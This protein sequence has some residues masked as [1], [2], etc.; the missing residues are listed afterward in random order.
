MALLGAILDVGRPKVSARAPEYHTAAPP[1]HGQKYDV[2]ELPTM[3]HFCLYSNFMPRSLRSEV[4]ET[5]SVCCV[6][7]LMSYERG[8]G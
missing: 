1:T 8:A 2:L 7:S 5:C 3:H 6:W 4:N